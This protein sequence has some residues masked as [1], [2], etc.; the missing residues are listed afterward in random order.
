[1]PI[2]DMQQFADLRRRGDSTVPD[3]LN[4]LRGHRARLTERIRQ[5]QANGSALDDKIDNY[6]QLLGDM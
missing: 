3:R 6:E 5:L 2:T 1:M 4:L